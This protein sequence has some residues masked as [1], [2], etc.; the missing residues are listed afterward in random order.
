MSADQIANM[1]TAEKRCALLKHRKGD[2]IKLIRLYYQK[3]GWTNQGVPEIQTL[4]RI[5]LWDYLNEEAR[6]EIA[7]LS[8]S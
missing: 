5:G 1:E 3:R 7:R 6:A 4:R 8:G 2:L